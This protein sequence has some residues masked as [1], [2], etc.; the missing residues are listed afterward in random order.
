MSEKKELVLGLIGVGRGGPSSYHARSFS[1][2]INGFKK[3]EVP[4][5]WHECLHSIPAKGARIGSVWDEDKDAAKHLAKVFHIDRVE[6]RMEDVAEHVD[7]V[8]IV[9]DIS[10]T[11]QKK[12]DFFLENKVPTFVDK[13]LAMTYEEAEGIINKAKKYG[14]LFMTGSALRYCREIPEHKSEIDAVGR[15]DYGTTVCQGAYMGEDNI[16]HYGI[17]ALEFAYPV[18]GRGAV[19]VQNIGEGRKHVVKI[20]FDDGRILTLIV[21]PEIEQNFKLDLFGTKGETSVICADW[22]YFYWNM[23]QHFIDMIKTNKEPVPIEESL[24][25]IKVLTMAKKSVLNNGIKIKL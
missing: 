18:F 8:L 20:D 14:G 21:M 24:E 12:A 15:I 10:M 1:S 6:N 4:E 25:V 5:E 23:L 9:D 11:H 22:D 19:A 13:P 17:H 3:E 2:I 16:I 7:G